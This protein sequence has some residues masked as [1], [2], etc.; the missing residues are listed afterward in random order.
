MFK[1]FNKKLP[2]PINFN[3]EKFSNRLNLIDKNFLGAETTAKA[4]EMESYQWD[5]NA[6]KPLPNIITDYYL[7]R[8]N[9]KEVKTKNL[10]VAWLLEPISIYPDMYKWVRRNYHHFHYVFTHDKKWIKDIPN[11]VWIPVGGT[12][13]EK[14]Q[15][16]M[17]FFEKKKN[18][19]FFCSDKMHT[20]GHKLRNEIKN[21]A[22]SSLI[23]MWGT[24]W[25][26][27]E[28]KVDGLKEYRFHITIE[29]CRREGYFTEK[30]I[31]CFLTGVVPIYWGAPDIGNYFASDGII[32]FTDEKDLTIKLSNLPD[33]E[34]F[35]PFIIENYQKALDYVACDKF[36]F[37][38]FYKNK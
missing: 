16:D 5:R 26:Y 21:G 20:D 33:Y 38:F 4:G 12:W 2:G 11:A 28:N 19:S 29:N 37:D 8:K 24:G 36:L 18:I 27:L 6:D 22:V 1:F 25:K 31:D 23:D 10:K 17:Y 7:S 35:K 13:I 30:I 3:P 32:N 34:K 9:F 15:R 14:N